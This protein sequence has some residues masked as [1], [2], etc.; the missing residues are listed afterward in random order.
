ML[1]LAV[2]VSTAKLSPVANTGGTADGSLGIPRLA[3]LPI[4]AKLFNC[5]LPVPS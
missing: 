1:I 4:L 3:V 5:K 2:L